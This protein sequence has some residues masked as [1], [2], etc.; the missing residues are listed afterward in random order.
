MLLG[1]SGG[2]GKDA[3]SVPIITSYVK[4]QQCVLNINDTSRSEVV[5]LLMDV[6][7][8]GITTQNLIPRE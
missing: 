6:I 5:C 3:I 7:I 1:V 4:V 8:I 2:S